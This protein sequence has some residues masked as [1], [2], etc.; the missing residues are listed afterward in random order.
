[1]S[2]MCYVLLYLIRDIK[3]ILKMRKMRER[4]NL[5]WMESRVDCQGCKCSQ[6]RPLIG[7]IFE[8]RGSTFLSQDAQSV[9]T[10]SGGGVQRISMI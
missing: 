9:H 4:V 2:K 8:L 1:M 7:D 3:V 6:R 10:G 5:S